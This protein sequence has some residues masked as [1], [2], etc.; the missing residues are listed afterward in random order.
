[1]R[2]LFLS[3]GHGED[4]IGSRLAGQ[5]SELRPGDRM[6][7]FPLVGNGAAWREKGISVLGEARDLPSGGLTF[8]SARNL[9]ADVRA[10]LLPV[11]WRQL[12][13]LRKTSA[14]AVVVTGDIWALTL[15]LLP[16][17][18]AQRRF[19]IQTL[20]S[21]RQQAGTLPAPQRLFMERITAPERLLQRRFARRVWLRDEETAAWLRE[22]AVPQARYAGSLIHDRKPAGTRSAHPERVLLLPGSRTWAQESLALL[23][24][25]AELLPEVS[26]RVAWSRHERPERLP[27]GWQLQGAGPGTL[28]K[29]TAAVEFHEHAFERLLETADA[30]VGTAGTAAE[31]VAAAGLPMLSFELPA[32]HTRG[33]LANQ[34][35]ILGDALHVAESSESTV[36]AR[37]LSGLLQD[38]ELRQRASEAGSRLLGEPG[39]LRR[40]A[41]EI[42]E[43][44]S[45]D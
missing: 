10:G 5:L 32:R 4:V 1:M 28:S 21:T 7:A 38:S 24:P 36:L 42:H 11:T 29:G 45:V 3:N 31:Q 35:R 13:D 37:K 8:H 43:L 26:F 30:A 19:V 22:R 9:L 40:I 18:P 17:V 20:V 34:R 41:A 12:A 23:L 25:L 6:Q 39:G 16:E 27:A 15:S 33:F 2:L 14:D 44:L